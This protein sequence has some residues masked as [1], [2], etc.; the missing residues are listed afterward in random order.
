[1]KDYK[2]L[3]E[4]KVPLVGVAAAPLPND[5][6]TWHGNLR[7]PPDTKWKDGV[8]HFEMKIPTDYPVNPPSITL[9]TTIPHPNVFGT[10]LCLDMLQ[11]GKKMIYETGWVPAYTIEAILIQLQ[12]FL[13]EDIP[14]GYETQKNL[15]I[16][17]ACK[18]AN[19]FKCP[20]CKHRGP[21][22]ADP[23]FPKNEKNVEDFIMQ[24]TPK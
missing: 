13:F 14:E 9:F 23:P 15:L 5:M 6:F 12:S 4:A 10:T 2:E 21:L 24:K 3:M 17:Q 18:N 16:S 20:I 19:D 1:M 22:A 8:F 7:G 11:P